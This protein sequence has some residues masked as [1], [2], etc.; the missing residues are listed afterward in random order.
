MND[1][2]AH[3]QGHLTPS[4]EEVNNSN[5]GSQ[6]DLTLSLLSSAI[7][8]PACGRRTFTMGY[9]YAVG[10]L[11]LIWS[12]GAEP[13][14]TFDGPGHPACNNV[15]KVYNA[16]SVEEMQSIVRDAIKSNTPVRASG[17]GMRSKS[18]R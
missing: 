1:V 18:G 3:M 5:S 7:P 9:R 15:A 13:F 17:K 10:I 4:F 14:N 16:T 2:L 11:A 12:S 6:K 8:W